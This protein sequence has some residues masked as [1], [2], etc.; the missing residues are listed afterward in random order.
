MTDLFKIHIHI[1]IQP[2]S[3]NVC[4][5]HTSS[6]ENQLQCEFWVQCSNPNCSKHGCLNALLNKGKEAMS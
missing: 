1:T 5:H 6:S 2:S 3:V 4:K